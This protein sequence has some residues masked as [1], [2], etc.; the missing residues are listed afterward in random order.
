[1]KELNTRNLDN[2]ITGHWGEDRFRSDIRIQYVEFDI[3]LTGDMDDIEKSDIESMIR[4]FFKHEY[5]EVGN[6]KIEKE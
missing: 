6:I 5:V 3:I 2:Y 4:M 1:M